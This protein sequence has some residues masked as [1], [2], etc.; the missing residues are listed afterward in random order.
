MRTIKEQINPKSETYKIIIE[1]EEYTEKVYRENNYFINVPD[2]QEFSWY[3]N[4]F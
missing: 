2:K 4:L 3:A 1:I